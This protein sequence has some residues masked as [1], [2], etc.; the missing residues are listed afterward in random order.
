MRQAI[1]NGRWAITIPDAIA[2]WDAVTGD[3]SARRGWEFERFDDMQR[4]LRYGDCLFDIGAEHGWISAILAREFVGAENMVLFEPSPDFWTNIRKTWEYNGLRM[5]M[6]MW[7]GFVGETSDPVKYKSWASWPTKAVLEGPECDAMAYRSLSNPQDIPTISIDTFVKKTGMYPHALNIDIEG[8]ELL[9]LR[10]ASWVLT[11]PC[12]LH[13]VWVS[14]HP[15]LMEN[16]GHTPAQLDKF[17]RG[18]GWVG[19]FLGE[20]HEQHFRYERMPF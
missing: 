18:C 14:V 1:V 2:D 6:A 20:D 3:Y 8:A 19:V 4:H 16:F 10:G 17:M 13:H 15:D 7:P 11:T 12:A 5:P 9:A